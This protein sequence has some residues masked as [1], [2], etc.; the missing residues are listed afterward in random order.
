MSDP[1]RKSVSKAIILIEQGRYKEAIKV[2]N[3]E[4]SQDPANHELLY[5]LSL[6]QY[7]VEDMQ[8][9]SLQT[10]D[11]AIKHE[12]QEPAYFQLRSLI[13]ADLKRPKLALDSVNEALRLDPQYAQ[14]HASKAYIYC[15]MEKWKEAEQCARDALSF[16]ADNPFA[17]NIL[18]NSLRMQNKLDESVHLTSDLLAKDPDSY[19]S[20]SNRGWVYLHK[21]DYPQAQVHFR[22]ALRLHP[23]FEPARAGMLEV[24]RAKSPLYRLYLQYAFFMS[25]QTKSIRIMVI[26]GIYVAFRSAMKGLQ[27]VLN[28]PYAFFGYVAIV[29]LYSLLFWTWLAPGIGNLLILTDSFARHSL[30]RKE[31]LDAVFVGG[32][33]F[34]GVI[35]V[36]TGILLELK[37][38]MLVGF[39][40][41]ASAIPFSMT[42]TNSHRIGKFFY[43]GA[44]VYILVVGL[45]ASIVWGILGEIPSLLSAVVG[46]TILLFVIIS[47]LGAFR[48]LQE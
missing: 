17:G 43:G 18:V 15:G 16:D 28:G 23:N 47:W 30:N 19:L 37:P 35:L 4:L 11:E 6:A 44:G 40:L 48:F 39:A 31:K 8:K 36:L 42:F 25:Q 34:A 41:A 5:Y 38:I 13:L 20:H 2:F 9:Q 45:M 33:F 26:I 7:H 1:S 3:D 32:S 22:E 21:K 14:A 24:F 12:T 29:I 10:I 27:Q 46:F